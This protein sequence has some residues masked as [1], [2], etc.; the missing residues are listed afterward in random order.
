MFVEQIK[1]RQQ[2]CDTF[3]KES[4][5]ITQF[6]LKYFPSYESW[7]HFMG[8]RKKGNYFDSSFLLEKKLYW[9]LEKALRILL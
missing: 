7:N 5:Y 8:Q 9:I 3:P 6:S 1:V 2:F 4:K